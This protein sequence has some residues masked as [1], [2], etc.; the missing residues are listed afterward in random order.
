MPNKVQVGDMGIDGRIFPVGTKPAD[1]DGMFAPGGGDGF[2]VQVKQVDKVGRPDVDQFEAVMERE[3]RQRGFFV[4]FGY[5]DG[6][7][8]ECAAFHQRTGR[9]IKL[10]S[11]QEILDEQHVQK[12]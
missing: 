8:S 1:T 4:S 10:L 7:E 5:T 11:V 6:A 12:M 2:P 9:L 3:N